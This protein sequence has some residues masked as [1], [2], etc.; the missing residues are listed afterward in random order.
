MS[1]SSLS[2]SSTFSF[3]IGLRRAFT[4]AGIEVHLHPELH[5]GAFL[6]GAIETFDM[7]LDEVHEL[8][9][10]DRAAGSGTA[11]LFGDVVD[12]AAVVVVGLEERVFEIHPVELD[13][14]LERNDV[15]QVVRHDDVLVVPGFVVH[16][17]QR[18]AAIHVHRGLFVKREDGAVEFPVGGFAGER[19]LVDPEVPHDRLQ[20]FL[21]VFALEA[22]FRI[23]VAESLVGNPADLEFLLFGETLELSGDHT[24]LLRERAGLE[25]VVDGFI[26]MEFEGEHLLVLLFQ[27]EVF[28][29]AVDRVVENAEEVVVV[30]ALR[31][32]DDPAPALDPELFDPGFISFIPRL[33]PGVFHG[34]LGIAHEE[35]RVPVLADQ[36]IRF[37]DVPLRSWLLFP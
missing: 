6:T 30:A 4:E 19:D 34:G 1:N 31:F 2:K 10:V 25:P 32:G 14:R 28:V 3:L 23:D 27:A 7:S 29:H 13:S 22:V 16:G 33:S 37:H 26:G 12:P 20:V 17:D 35:E 18:Q 15:R 36:R 9:D 21:S 11:V 5:E 24:E 8:L